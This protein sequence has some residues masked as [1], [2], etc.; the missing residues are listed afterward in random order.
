MTTQCLNH[1][2][3]VSLSCSKEL[4]R[5]RE[6]GPT[7]WIIFV[8]EPL[9]FNWT[10][11]TKNLKHPT[12][13]DVQQ[14]AFADDFSFVITAK[15]ES[16]LGIIV[17]NTLNILNSW[18]TMHGLEISKEK[19]TYIL[20][21]SK[22]VNGPVIKLNNT[23]IKRSTSV[24]LLGLIID[25]QINW[26][27]HITTQGNKASAKLQAIQRIAGRSW[28]IKREHRLIL[29][30]A[31][32]VRM[33]AHGASIWCSEPQQYLKDKIDSVQRKFLLNITGAYRTTP[34]KALQVILGLPPLHLTLQQE[35]IRI[36]LLKD[37]FHTIL[38]DDLIISNKKIDTKIN[39]QTIHPADFNLNTTGNIQIKQKTDKNRRINIYTDGSKM[40][41]GTGAAIIIFDG[42]KS[43]TIKMKFFNWNTIFQ[44]EARAILEAVQIAKN[45]SRNTT[46]W[47]DSLSALHAIKNY[48]TTHNIIQKIQSILI[49]HPQLEISWIK[50]HAGH[51]GN[52]E[53]DKAAK[54]AVTDKNLT[55]TNLGMPLS[56]IKK[57]EKEFI[58]NYWQQ[59][60][61]AHKY[62]RTTYEI[63]P[64]VSFKNSKWPKEL[65][66]FITEHGPFRTYLK[67]FQLSRHKL[68]SCGEIGSPLHYAT[69]C[70][71]TESYHFKIP[72]EQNIIA[73]KKQIITK[74]NCVSSPTCNSALGRF[75]SRSMPDH[76]CYAFA[77]KCLQAC[78][79]LPWPA[80]SPDLSPIEHMM[81]RRF[82]L[83]RNFDD[84]VRQLDRIWQ[85]IPQE[86][87]RELHRSMP[88][89]V[90]ACI[91]ARGGSTPY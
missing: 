18:A 28:G 74:P 36:N 7:S 39:L 83:A 1:Y 27:E 8:D 4:F 32:I 54:E 62:G 68:C 75:F 56:Y 80:R 79:T 76:K 29:Y 31:C 40:E 35:A 33:L 52:E 77:M 5:A 73:W 89:R 24:N 41:A 2:V 22:L 85:E 69:K 34:T 43:N 47:T 38:I 14:F 51:M 30:K 45:N 21:K 44:A 58:L 84:L 37:S 71:L 91:Q 57:K 64:K 23:K 82:H 72:M 49:N 55:S 65:I 26:S 86:T 20:I 6:S 42:T 11:A 25:E 19:T 3:V 50:A 9:Q 15:T 48:N 67:R 60:W 88:R 63:L 87:I 46:I 16:D 13:A 66:M 78:Q 17:T 53:A 10:E 81:G 70:L 61:I 59:L 90:A 12:E